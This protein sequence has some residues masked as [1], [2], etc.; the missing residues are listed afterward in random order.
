VA[1]VSLAAWVAFPLVFYLVAAG[2]GLLAA[3]A[4]RADLPDA[5]LAPTGACLSI[6]IVTLALELGADG[7]VL[8]AVLVVAAA[9]GLLV[10]RRGLSRRLLPGWAGV[11]PLLAFALY[12]GPVVLTGHWT[13][14]GYNFVN[15]TATN[16]AVID[17]I[18]HHGTEPVGGEVSTRLVVVNTT[19]TQGYPLGAHALVGGL[20][21][22][23]PAPVEAVYQPFIACVAAFAAMALAWLAQSLR[24][25]R[26]AA[27]LIALVAVG[28]N[29]TYH[30]ALHGAFKEL[31]V[32]MVVATAAALCRFV[33]DERLALGPV[34]LLAACLVAAA[35]I[36]TVGAAGYAVALV[37]AALV[38]LARERLRIPRRRLARAVA[39]G[40]AVAV[41]VAT[42]VIAESLDFA[43]TSSRIFADSNADLSAPLRS[44]AVLGHLVRPLPVYQSLGT[45]LR[46][47]YRYPIRPG[48]ARTL[49]TVLLVV[50]GALLAV[51]LAIDWRRRRLGVLLAAAP[52]L[53]VYLVGAPRLEPYAEAKLLV[54]A[55][56]LVVFGAGVGAWWLLRRLRVAGVVVCAA[57][58][59][60]VLVS[61][62]LA[63][64][65]AR[66]APVNRL[67]AL[68]EAA[69]HAGPGAVLLPEWEEFAKHF[70][71]AAAI[72]VGPEAF[73]P[74][75]FEL[76]TPEPVFNRSF[77]LDQLRP[78]YVTSW[79][80]LLLRRS[81][82]ASR[83]P[84][85]YRLAFRNHWYEL[86][87]RQDEPVVLDHLPLQRPGQPAAVPRC[88]D[89]RALAARAA[90]GEQ[91][92]AYRRPPLPTIG[93][94]LTPAPGTVRPD[95]MPNWPPPLDDPSAAVP[96]G[97]GTISARLTLPAGTY[98]VWVKG[99]GGRPLAVSVDGRPTG[100]V[101]EVN[102]P[103]GWL[104]YGTVR[105]PAGTHT[106]T[107]TRPGA[108]LKPGNGFS[109]ALSRIALEPLT[110]RSLVTV[111]PAQADRLCDRT[112]D[113]IE[114]VRGAPRS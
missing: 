107:L 21:R 14:L 82:E 112:W 65:S 110:P 57:L 44:P 95:R 79:P 12:L 30:Y 6:V 88:Q 51:A 67:E 2:I 35:A 75:P 13:W 99:G 97:H 68:R 89:V 9:G 38:A 43:R 56:P 8:A 76:R 62:A 52:A 54:I 83:P 63:Y 101:Q 15:D 58:A 113:W 36:F 23:V 66:I 11:A 3:R 4:V 86:W 103:G 53:A 64:H 46:A 1:V 42:P 98:R 27:A 85:S 111:P 34:A 104:M 39:V 41:V 31:S 49:T 81:P 74:R 84:A 47:D 100:A 69:E 24:V 29:L 90:D 37:V 20:V 17:H 102:T 18:A 28:A 93:T 40:A 71:A 60:G 73:S 72:D 87:R 77:D 70:G 26:P 16:L 25:P 109:G 48:A 10:G 5:L 91:L 7:V 78:G 55:S 106:V 105:V 80:W 22:I 108:D 45:W 50:A 92:V 32:V 96:T 61:D 19:L 114:L 94:A 33:L 59:G